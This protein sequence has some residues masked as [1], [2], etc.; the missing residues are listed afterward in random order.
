MNQGSQSPHLPPPSNPS[1]VRPTLQTY[2]MPEASNLA[3]SLPD[4]SYFISP[5]SL[6][7]QKDQV[8][9]TSCHSY[10]HSSLPLTHPSLPL[11]PT[12][13]N[14]P[15]PLNFNPH[16]SASYNDCLSPPPSSLPPPCFQTSTLVPYP[17][18]PLQNCVSRP[19][20]PPVTTPFIPY[21]QSR[22]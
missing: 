17:F 22:P 15:M 11:Y 10:S 1:H 19:T 2:G 14:S 6:G 9:A 4:C 16:S 7:V 20:L 21:R 5:P 8:H 12:S 18:T 3:S 13:L